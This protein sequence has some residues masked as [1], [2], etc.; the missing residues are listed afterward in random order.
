MNDAEERVVLVDADDVETGTMDKL[1][2]HEA[3]VLHRAVSVFVLDGRGRLIL[4]RRAL[5]KYHGGGLWSNTCCGHPR[6]GELPDD[7]AAR[8]LR[9]EMGLDIPLERVTRFT[10]RAAVGGLTEH[11]VDHVYLGTTAALPDPDPAEV[12]EWRAVP[13]ADAERELQREPGRFTPWFSLALA[14]LREARPGFGE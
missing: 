11:E 9:E 12:A 13:V 7:A 2:A 3:G 10:Y 6:P 5:D 4:Q 1:A 14:A 8:R